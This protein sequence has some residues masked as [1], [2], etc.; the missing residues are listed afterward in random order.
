MLKAHASIFFFLL[1]VVLLIPQDIPAEQGE[2]L[3]AHESYA[4]EREICLAPGE[5]YAVTYDNERKEFIEFEPDKGY[6]GLPDRAFRQVLRS[7]L[8]LREKFIDRLVDLYYDDID[9]GED[10]A[11][12]FRDVNGDE[13]R[14]L[15]IGNAAG[16]LKCFLA[17][18]F[19]ENQDFETG[20]IGTL[21]FAEGQ[22]F[23]LTGAEDGSITVITNGEIDT[24][25]EDNLNRIKVEGNSRPIFE[26]VTGDGLPDLLIGAS[27]GTISVYQNH[28]TI[29]DWWF[30]SY[31]TE[32]ERKFDDDVGYLSSSCI[33]DVNGDDVNDIV[34]GAKDA[35]ELKIYYGPEY[36]DTGGFTY[37]SDFE[38]GNSG[39]MVPALGDYN[40]DGRCDHAVGFDDGT[41]QVFITDE[42]YVMHASEEFSAGLSVPG[43]ATPCSA[44]FDGDEIC[45]MVIGAGDGSLYFFRGNG[46][47]FERVEGYFD[48][49]E[50]GEYPSPAGYDFNHD[51]RIDLVVGNKA[52]QIRVFLAPDW[53]EVEGG[54]GLVN[55]GNFTSP[56]FGD[57][58]GDDWPELLIGSVDGTLRYYEGRDASWTECYSWQFHQLFSGGG[59][60]SYLLRTHPEAT[61]L[62]GMNDDKALN[63]FLE[64]LE[65]CGEEYFDEV[66]F[67]FSNIQTE[68]LRTMSRL[69]NAD[70]LL[71]N[72]RAIYDFASRVKY[73][74]IREKGDYTTIEYVSEDG[75]LTEMPRDVYYWW[76]VHPVVEYEIPSRIDASYW[77]DDAEYYGIT[78][79]EWTRK[80]ITIDEYEH[81]AN[82]H[83]WRTF[84]AEDGRYGGNLL[85][86]VEQAENIKEAAYLIAD[87][88][89]FSG[90][91][92][93]RWNEYGLK[94]ND[95]QPLVIYEKNYGSCGEQAMICVAFSRTALIPNAPVGCHGEDHAWN[96]WWMDGQ[97]YQWDVG[98]A[99]TGLGHPWN[100]RRGHTGTPLLSI[101]QRR[102]DGLVQNT[103]TRPVNPPG[104][105]YNPGNAPGYTEVGHVTIRVVDEVNEPVEGALV[106]I[107]SRWNNYYRTSIWD[108][109]DPEGYC[110]FELG[111]PITGSCVADV[112][113][114][115][116]TTG[117]EYFIVRENEEFEYTYRLPGRFCRRIPDSSLPG[118]N[119]FAA[120]NIEIAVNVIEEEQRPQNFST[121]R[122]T[123]LA[124]RK[125][126]EATGYYGT[127]WYSEPNRD[128]Y[129][130]YSTI[131]S[132]T[133]YEDFMATHELPRADWTRDTVYNKPFEPEAG[134][135]Y[136]FYNPN[137]YTHVR[138][139]AALTAELPAESPEIEL[140]TTPT[141]ARIGERVTFGG[142][143]SDNLHVGAL[144][145]S[146]NG[147][148]DFND[149]TDTYD[150][151]AGEFAYIWDT[152]AGGPACPGEYNVVFRVED[153]SSGFHETNGINFTLETAREFKDQVIYQDKT[154]SPLPVSSWVL[155]P[156]TVGENERFLGIQGNSTDADLDM[157][158]F[159]F[160]DKNG[161][162]SL[163]GENEQIAKSTSPSATESIL[164][165]D[166][167]PGVY[168]IFCQGWRV[169][170]RTDVDIWEEI[171]QLSPGQLLKLDP[172]DA[173]RMAAYGLIDVSISFNFTP[174]FIVD[175]T[176]TKKL[177]ITSPEISGRFKEGFN[178]DEGSFK[179][180]FESE[181][182]SEYATV[183]N[184]G[185]NISLSGMSLQP[186]VEYP[187]QIEARTTNGLQDNIELILTCTEPESVG[188]GH[189]VIEDA[190]I[191]VVDINVLEEDTRLESARARIDDLDWYGLELEDGNNSAHSEIP[192]AD[193][194]SGEHVLVV[195]YLVAGG[196]PETKELTF[197]FN[198]AADE[199]LLK[200]FPGDGAQV[201]DHQSAIIAYYSLEIRNDVTD[202]EV[203]LDNRDISDLV[204]IYSDGIIYLPVE[205]YAEG[206]HAFE[207]I[208]KLDDGRVIQK[209]ITFTILAM[210]EDQNGMQ[211]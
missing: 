176:P 22:G 134:D 172:S 152:G 71:E 63:E 186:G 8:W 119:E 57:L 180:I 56:A 81:N 42:N 175:V 102:G 184:E 82:A 182:I 3:I 138:F 173:D 31:S 190:E 192:L 106:V 169:N 72:A 204:I 162:R 163:D 131:L 30:V 201:Y 185:F 96:E 121:G 49:L 207:V 189:T 211:E 65:D 130:V 59:I 27:D 103:T 104:S 166:P 141:S 74:S 116:G 47:G 16:E 13:L 43:F 41:V 203:I 159:L 39:T 1:I 61:L 200:I 46:H 144:K 89:T 52:G 143:A 161:N 51:T 115:L 19:K 36:T 9:V 32:T 129:G 12:V 88:I 2:T 91:R 198:R 196:I 37:A 15:V 181:D 157:D 123:S 66:V 53:V 95:L 151:S 23:S 171:R 79:E 145:V 178:V 78:E 174:A 10:A 68:M 28:G 210:D 195:E 90:S 11:P 193:L 62:R 139:E 67:A 208:I 5:F 135:V 55:A 127:R 25:L 73:A 197:L 50:T 92:P 188:I 170:Y 177:L 29:G 54:L 155:G 69:G 168:W 137:R 75:T 206:D 136:F 126:Y 150:R 107:R 99:I 70:L 34:C 109:T 35:L 148:I 114:P 64:V 179:V 86:V 18:Y 83:F 20:D 205:T 7:P 98:H 125:L 133:E 120:N 156:F 108:Y 94:S 199:D 154:D 110:Y 194:E 14:D 149:I 187:V 44:D 21:A 87:W 160:Y 142:Q 112:I 122:G 76:V 84:L 80:E 93:G 45:D 118:T 128:T 111:N 26:D 97:W 167:G 146:F 165:H 101:T 209:M 124:G 85:D 117:T 105:N 100:E 58:T 77:R 140:L 6:Q 40:G 4:F 202:V 24:Q 164:Y 147:G 17:P 33:E 38:F 153:G 48:G 113:T 158:L 183:D 132:A 60:E 191:I